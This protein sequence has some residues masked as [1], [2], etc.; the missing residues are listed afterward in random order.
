MPSYRNVSAKLK[1]LTSTLSASR[2]ETI[3]EVLIAVSTIIGMF[4]VYFT[5]REM[6]IY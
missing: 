5:L 4:L 2:I 6:E 3:F 1:K